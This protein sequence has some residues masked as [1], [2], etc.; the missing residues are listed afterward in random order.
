M[1]RG[2]RTWATAGAV[3]GLLSMGLL[4]AHAESSTPE[5]EVSMSNPGEAPVDGG[6]VLGGTTQSTDPTR[7]DYVPPAGDDELSPIQAKSAIGY[8]NIGGF[9]FN[10]GGVAIGVPGFVM[11]HGIISGSTGLQISQEY[12]NYSFGVKVQ[13]C[14][15]QTAFQN[16]SGSTIY[17][18]RWAPKHEGCIVGFSTGQSVNG[19]FNVKNGA[20][21]AR[22]Y[23]NGAFKGEQCHSVY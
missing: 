15:F 6:V 23:V 13:L 7:Y 22:L 3:L 4:P 2:I 11:Q 19:P 18:T 12:A 1:K 10:Y 17:S 5:D 20:E 14:N 9:T 21:C 16:R 8:A